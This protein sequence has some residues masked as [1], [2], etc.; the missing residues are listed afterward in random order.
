MSE[1]LTDA[2]LDEAERMAHKPWWLQAPPHDFQP[3]VLRLV[4]EVRRLRAQVAGHAQR[5][6]DQSELLSKRAERVTPIPPTT[7]G[8]MR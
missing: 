1:P 5:I 7:D 6:A 8:L 4:A 2:E 3:A